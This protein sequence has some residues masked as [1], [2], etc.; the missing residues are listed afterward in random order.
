M[1]EEA[2]NLLRIQRPIYMQVG[3]NQQNSPLAREVHNLIEEMSLL[4]IGGTSF[5][6]PKTLLNRLSIPEYRVLQ[7]GMFMNTLTGFLFQKKN[8]IP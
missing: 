7:E 1:R 6:F 8:I 4:F 3:A 2:F 5:P